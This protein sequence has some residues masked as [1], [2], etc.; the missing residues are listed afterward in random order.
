MAIFKLTGF[1]QTVKQKKCDLAT[2]NLD[3]TFDS[4]VET[5]NVQEQLNEIKTISYR[6]KTATM[7][8]LHTDVTQ[9]RC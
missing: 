5:L 2:R 1:F 9:V 4:D 7:L 3:T 8:L 6:P